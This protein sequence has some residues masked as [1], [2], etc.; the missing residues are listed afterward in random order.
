[1]STLD[2]DALDALALALAEQQQTPA[3]AP[4][5]ATPRRDAV[6]V[7]PRCRDRIGGGPDGWARHD[8]G[9]DSAAQLMHDNIEQARE[10]HRD[11]TSLN[12]V[13]RVT[14]ARF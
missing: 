10:E 9:L 13:G 7:C 8:A 12:Y 5:P 14:S 2:Q 1:M 11:R 6:R 4:A 3:P